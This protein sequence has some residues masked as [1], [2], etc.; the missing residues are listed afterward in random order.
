MA[1]RGISFSAMYW[2]IGGIIKDHGAWRIVS[3]GINEFFGNYL[4]VRG[5]YGL[6][7][8]LIL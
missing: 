8:S 1:T 6:V 4:R 5:E 7:A 3:D 2:R